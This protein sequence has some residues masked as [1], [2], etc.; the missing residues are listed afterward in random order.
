[1]V[2]L[3]KEFGFGPR[4]L[5][6]GRGIRK[7][8]DLFPN[9]SRV[10]VPY[11]RNGM[12]STTVKTYWDLSVGAKFQISTHNNIEGAKQP[13]DSGIRPGT[14]G[15]VMGRDEKTCSISLNIGGASKRLGL[16]WLETAQRGGMQYLPIVNVNAKEIPA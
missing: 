3:A 8:A 1:M 5:G 7:S 12:L 2:A 9:E 16:W 4:A 10:L 11:D 14:V 13:S 15:S 6:R